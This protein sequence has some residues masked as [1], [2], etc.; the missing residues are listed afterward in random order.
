MALL[1]SLNGKQ[2]FLMNPGTGQILLYND[3]AA[4]RQVWPV[5][6]GFPS[7]Y[8]WNMAPDGREHSVGSY[9]LR[10]PQ[11]QEMHPQPALREMEK[12]GLINFPE[13]STKWKHF[14]D[15]LQSS[16]GWVTEG[17]GFPCVCPVFPLP[18]NPVF[19]FTSPPIRKV[20]T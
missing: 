4:H 6:L 19:K 13:I 18:R 9:G 2:R 3:V 7:S 12:P 11:R 1:C 16:W 10:I 14:L 8:P 15:S 17:G 5:V 20:G